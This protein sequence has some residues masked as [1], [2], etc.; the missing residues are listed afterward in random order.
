[1]CESAPPTEASPAPTAS[2]ARLPWREWISAKREQSRAYEDRTSATPARS[3]PA[4]RRRVPRI[5]LVYA[6]HATD[7][8]LLRNAL[9]AYAAEN[10]DHLRI[11]YFAGQLA[12][13]AHAER[14]VKVGKIE[15]KEVA[16]YVGRPDAYVDPSR[17]GVVVCGPEGCAASVGGL[18]DLLSI[19]HSF[20]DAMA[21][22]RV[23]G[24]PLDARVPIGGL[25]AQFGWQPE[26]VVRLDNGH[27]LSQSLRPRDLQ[28]PPAPMAA[29]G[30]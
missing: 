7:G 2:A 15:G 28:R 25:L 16:K 11:A 27:H 21:G 4:S 30:Q 1:M 26:Q 24:A 22:P 12:E 17:V 9:N 5:T 29:A 19:P 18:A 23:K 10:P 3:R 6:S 13:P 8:I 20:I 14:V